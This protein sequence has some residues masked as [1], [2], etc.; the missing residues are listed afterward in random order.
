MH[1]AP[2]SDPHLRGLSSA[3]TERLRCHR[4]P[5]LD[6]RTLLFRSRLPREPPRWRQRPRRVAP[7]RMS[8]ALHRSLGSPVNGYRPTARAK[9]RLPLSSDLHPSPAGGTGRSQGRSSER[10]EHVAQSQRPTCRSALNPRP[11]RSIVPSEPLDPHSLPYLAHVTGCHFSG[12][13]T[14]IVED[15]PHVT[16]GDLRVGGLE[17]GEFFDH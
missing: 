9:G 6:D 15:G 17:R 11:L 10:S 13:D 8:T 1:R 3:L 4:N 16:V 12:S 7:K 14:G 5:R 2:S